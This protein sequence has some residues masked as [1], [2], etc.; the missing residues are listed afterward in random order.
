M[1]NPMKNDFAAGVI[2]EAL[3]CDGYEFTDHNTRGR[4]IGT[5]LA[6]RPQY[7]KDH[8]GKWRRVAEV[9]ERTAERA[10]SADSIVKVDAGTSSPC[11]NASGPESGVAQAA[12]EPPRKTTPSSNA[13]IPATETSMSVDSLLQTIV[14]NAATI[15]GRTY[16]TTE[17]FALML[18]VSLRTLHR[19][20]ED[21]K[22]PPKIKIP[23]AL[24]EL[25]EAL[26]WTADRNREI[27]RHH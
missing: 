13:T 6:K 7:L 4:F 16:I 17:Q 11:S 14:E 3:V 25:D 8:S 1:E 19:L 20:F 2:N 27:K 9:R 5:D 15:N 10:R 24:Y 12:V 21:D 22:G 26:K 18:D 23:G